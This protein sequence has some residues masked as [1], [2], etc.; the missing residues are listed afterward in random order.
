[1]DELG[2]G[3]AWVKTGRHGDIVLVIDD[4]A[5]LLTFVEIRLR[6]AAFDVTMASSGQEARTRDVPSASEAG[7]IL[8]AG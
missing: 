5:R 2:R 3:A 7:P 6:L 8:S 1:M 4:E